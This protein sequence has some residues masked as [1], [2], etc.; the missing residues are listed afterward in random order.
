[1]PIPIAQ[2]CPISSGNSRLRFESCCLLRRRTRRQR[3]FVLRRGQLWRGRQAPAS[4]SELWR[5]CP[6][7]L[8][9]VSRQCPDLL[10]LWLRICIAK[11]SVNERVL[12][13]SSTVL[14][15]LKNCLSL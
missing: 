3:P 8:P 6:S 2:V 10:H 15:A 12:S 5:R 4:E 7:R 9:K 13:F 1:G 14:T 11:G